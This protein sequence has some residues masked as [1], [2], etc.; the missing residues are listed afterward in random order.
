MDISENKVNNVFGSENRTKP[1]LYSFWIR[2]L[3]N[4]IS[5]NDAVLEVGCGR[6]YF[7]KK[8]SR[9]Y[10]PIGLDISEDMLSSITDQA[11]VP[12]FRGTAEKLPFKSNSFSAVIAFDVIEHLEYPEYFFEEASRVLRNSGFLFI[13]TPNPESFG[14]RIKQGKVGLKRNLPLARN[15]MWF[16]WRD[17][18]HINIRKRSEWKKLM[19]KNGLSVM[20][21]GTDTLWDIPYFKS[22]PYIFQK[23]VFISLH[24]TL[25]LL[26]G[27]FPW[28]LGENYICIAKKSEG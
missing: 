7:L 26:F 13:S 8:L 12:L 23:I 21:D 11:S 24:W 3:K 2:K 18:T 25:T 22:V 6:G 15:F 14:S 17:D 28:R 20:R 16:G 4:I 5:S 10:K 1:Y 19:T 9:R 27:F